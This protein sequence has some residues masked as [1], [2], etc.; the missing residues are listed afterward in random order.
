M[1]DRRITSAVRTATGVVVSSPCLFY[2]LLLSTK[3][4]NAS[5][6]ICNAAAA[7]AV[8]KTSRVLPFY[9]TGTATGS[10]P[11]LLE[12]PLGLATGLFL[13]MAGA[14]AHA[15]VYYTLRD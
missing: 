6:V 8:P 15:I 5:A 2:G 4:G 13:S 3:A 14:A 11:L 7:T 9:K 10:Y 12:T 1:A